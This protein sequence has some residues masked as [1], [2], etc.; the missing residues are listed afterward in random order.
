MIHKQEKKQVKE[1]DPE[2]N[3]TL[4]IIIKCLR[5]KSTHENNEK[6]NGIKM[7]Q[8]IL[9]ELKYTIS[10]MKIS[11]KGHIRRLENAKERSKEL[12]ITIN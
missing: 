11:L 10:E 3:K 5:I 1:T 2:E 12:E 7:I 6:R 4:K 9:L 8:M